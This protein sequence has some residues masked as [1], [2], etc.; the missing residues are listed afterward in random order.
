M[1]S[2]NG[3]EK[4]VPAMYRIYRLTFCNITM[5]GKAQAPNGEIHKVRGTWAYAPEFCV[6][7]ETE[8]RWLSGK[9]W[10]FVE[11]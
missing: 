9:E 7:D 3:T 2:R 6:Y 5:T 8:A 4:G 10:I 1:E 11:E